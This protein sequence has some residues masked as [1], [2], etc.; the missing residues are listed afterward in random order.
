MG[1]SSVKNLV[2]SVAE[3]TPGQ[4]DDWRKAWRAAADNGSAESLLSFI[5]RERGLAEDVFLQRLAKALGWP[6]RGLAQAYHPAGGAEQTFHEGGVSIF[7]AAHG[8]ERRRVAGGGQRS[9]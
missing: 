6:Y 9:V 7:R 4:F 5:A 3:T 8:G 2:A 1:F